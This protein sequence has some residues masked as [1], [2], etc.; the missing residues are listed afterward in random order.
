MNEGLPAN[1]ARSIFIDSKGSK[2]V[3]TSSGA[4]RLSGDIWVN[5]I[6][7]DK[8]V[9]AIFEDSNHNMWFGGIGE[10]NRYDGKELMRFSMKD[11]IQLEGRLVFPVTEDDN[12]N[13]WAATA[14]GA[15]IFDGINWSPMTIDKG[16]KH[17]VVHDVINDDKGRTWLA[18][19][20]GG[21]NI[22]DGET[23]KYFYP[24]KNCRKLLRDK[25]NNMWGGTSSGLLPFDGENWRVLVEGKTMLPMFEGKKG[26]IWCVSNGSHIVRVSSGIDKKRYHYQNPTAGQDNEIYDLDSDQ[27][28][29]VWAGT[30]QG[31]AVLH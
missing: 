30:D 22:Y 13:I 18:T 31:V 17:N 24:E 19:R 1:D 23:W 2:W 14:G 20:K 8:P 27:N 10:V 29:A 15:A 26:Y 25:K 5:E 11:D 16:L 21:L 12:G 4:A 3:G 7:I 6:I 9:I 28:G